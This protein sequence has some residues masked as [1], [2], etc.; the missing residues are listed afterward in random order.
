MSSESRGWGGSR[1]SLDGD[2]R[3]WL[4]GWPGGEG[5]FLEPGQ[6]FCFARALRDYSPHP[7]HRWVCFL[8]DF[9]D[10]LS[11]WQVESPV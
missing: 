9:Q 11:C 2:T 5:F 8:Q 3:C 6:G 7:G 1:V 10:G 4:G